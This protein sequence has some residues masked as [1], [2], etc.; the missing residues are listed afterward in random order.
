MHCIWK[1]KVKLTLPNQAITLPDFWMLNCKTIEL[2]LR[3]VSNNYMSKCNLTEG[4]A[5]TWKV[6]IK[7]CDLPCTYGQWLNTS[8]CPSAAPDF[9]LFPK[10][11]PGQVASCAMAAFSHVYG[12]GLGSPLLS[13]TRSW[14]L[15]ALP[16]VWA[17]TVIFCHLSGVDFRETKDFSLFKTSVWQIWLELARELELLGGEGIDRARP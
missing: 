17:I 4:Q 10:N 6:K 15:G 8:L 12:G 7:T 2:S 9:H 16:L 14:V 13:A 11:F 3:K 5:I 1:S